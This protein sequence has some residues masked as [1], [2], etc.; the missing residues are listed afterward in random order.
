MN[1]P[2]LDLVHYASLQGASDLHLSA[3]DY[4]IVRI[5]GDLYRAEQFP[6]FTADTVRALIKTVLSAHDIEK[7]N[8]QEEI[9]LAYTFEN[10]TRCRLNVY[11]HSLG[12]A[13]SFRLIPDKILSL[14]VLGLPDVLKTIGQ[15]KKGLVLVTGPTG[16]GKST[17]L[18]AMLD[19]INQTRSDHIITLEDPIEFV[20]ESKKSLIHQR[21]VHRDTNSFSQAL[22]AVLRED[23]DVILVGEMRDAETI[24]LALTAAE[25]GHLVLSTLH[26]NS[27]SKTIHRIVDVFQSEEKMLVRTLL[28]ES[29]Q[30]IIAQVLVKR[31]P[32]GRVAA[33]EILIGTPAIRN[34]IRENK[35]SQ[36]DSAIQTGKSMGMCTLE[37]SIQ[38]LWEK[39][40]V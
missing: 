17:T 14:D 36:I 30:A 6:K 33:H 38:M 31:K 12:L 28:S 19:Y 25:T 23:P 13:A 2:I 8:R 18:A 7:L 16:S 21:E 40:M 27:A 35:I 34:L 15:L 24:R 3:G 20:Y 1:I 26:T 11:Q 9:D 10:K 32:K 4:P 5:D 39:G 37:Q 22:R 29:L